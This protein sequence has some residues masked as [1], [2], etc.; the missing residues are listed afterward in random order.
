MPATPGDQAQ[1][2]QV[3]LNLIMNAIEAMSASANGV[4]DIKSSVSEAGD[5]LVT[6]A[7]SGPGVA[8]EDLDR[9]FDPFF[10]TKPEGLGMGL[11]ICRSIVETHGGRLWATRG[12]RGLVFHVFLPVARRS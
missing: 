12:D 7:D 9:M 11:S 8:V 2:E 6:V 3:F 10:T 1:L 4:L 5:V